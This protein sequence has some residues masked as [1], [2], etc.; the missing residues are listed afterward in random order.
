MI[1][2]IN[3][4][5]KEL[6]E[7]RIGWFSKEKLPYLVLCCLAVL[8]VCSTAVLWFTVS[9]AEK[10][11]NALQKPSITAKATAEKLFQEKKQHRAMEQQIAELKGI[12][13]GFRW[14]GFL[15]SIQRCLPEGIY[16][17][18]VSGKVKNTLS[19]SGESKSYDDIGTFAYSLEEIG[20]LENIRLK[21]VELKSDRSPLMYTFEIDCSL[22]KK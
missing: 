16:L 14:A 2:K 22:S 4:L 1:I 20:D 21:K 7:K 15:R 6:Q 8:I 5:P 9:F 17:T 19:I 12:K 10:E 11:V 18:K 13:P 3:L